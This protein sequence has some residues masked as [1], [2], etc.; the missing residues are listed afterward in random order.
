MVKP[1]ASWK[2]LDREFCCLVTQAKLCNTVAWL[3]NPNITWSL[4]MIILSHISFVVSFCVLL[5]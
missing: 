4:D 1:K 3:M 2:G 5:R